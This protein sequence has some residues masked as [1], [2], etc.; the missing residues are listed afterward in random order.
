MRKKIF[1]LAV[2]TGVLLSLLLGNRS[3]SAAAEPYVLGFITDITGTSRNN[4]A[5]EAEGFRCYMD[6]LNARGGINGH[7]IQVIIE[8]GRSE[9]SPSAAAA[10]KL[11]TMDNALAILGLGFTKAQPPVIELA[12]KSGVALIAGYMTIM[13]AWD[14]KPGSIAFA[15]GY[16][17][18]PG[19]HP[20]ACAAAEIVRKTQPKGA[21]VAVSSYAFPGGRISTDWMSE[22]CEKMGYKVVYKEHIPPGTVDLSPWANKVAASKADVFWG[23][24][25]SEVMFPLVLALEK[26]GY[27]K[28][29]VFPDFVTERDVAK[30]VEELKGK[31]VN[32]IWYGRYASV[33]EGKNI[34]KIQEIGSTMEKYNARYPISARH[35]QGWVMGRLLEKS[36][37]KAGWPCDRAGLIAALETT[38]IETDGLTGGP[39]HFTPTD[40]YGPVWFKA[41]K[42]NA[43]QKS[44]KP[45]LDWFSIKAKDFAKKK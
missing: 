26:A 1:V 9:P 7:P 5:P 11:I 28:D 23:Y 8:D 14:V 30:I 40:H 41:Y 24:F 3:V 45:F 44:L 19:Y 17:A 33:Y 34:P 42:C 18:H 22:L 39:I 32:L 38:Q 16:I 20:G 6:D 37:R 36:L 15:S 29:I 2:A 12:E 27:S 43:T 25:G 21:R 10:K 35:L 13:K 31:K 4:N